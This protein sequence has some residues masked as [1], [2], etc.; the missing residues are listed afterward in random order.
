MQSTSISEV[1]RKKTN[2]TPKNV[3]DE[4]SHESERKKA[5]VKKLLQD[6]E[7]AVKRRQLLDA[8]SISNVFGD[9]DSEIITSSRVQ[10]PLAISTDRLP[11]VKERHL[12]ASREILTQD[13]NRNVGRS[14]KKLKENYKLR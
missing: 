7:R 5:S 10:R 13:V 1:K 6:G 4:L 12:D 8:D 3:T 9:A 2:R 14:D 11:Q